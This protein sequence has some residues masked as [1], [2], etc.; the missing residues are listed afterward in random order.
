MLLR[1]T[2][3]AAA[4]QKCVT[5][6]RASQLGCVAKLRLEY[7]CAACTPGVPL[8]AVA[9]GAACKWQ[10]THHSITMASVCVGPA[11]KHLQWNMAAFSHTGDPQGPGLL[12]PTAP[13][14]Q[15][16]GSA[17]AIVMTI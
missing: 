16:S 12:P 11:C 5:N 8:G 6:L 1:I 4:L 10:H 15:S 17:H 7:K 9:L 14:L 13:P 2:A 3:Q